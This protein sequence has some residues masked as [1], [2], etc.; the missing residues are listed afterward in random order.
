MKT[1][2][3]LVIR[4]S[5]MGDVAM[6]VPIV[7]QLAQRGDVRVTVLTRK[8]FLPLFAQLNDVET[9]AFSKDL[10][11]L[12][13]FRELR[14]GQKWDTVIDLHNVLR[15]KFLRFL[16]RL[17]GV[18]IA[19]L[20][21]N[22]CQKR[23]LT[24]KHCKKMRQL[25]SVQD[26]YVAACA[27]AGFPVGAKIFSPIFSERAKDFSP[28][29]D[30]ILKITGE[31][32]IG[33]APFA[34]HR[35]KVYPLDKILQVIEHFSEKGV[36]IFLFGG[37]S[38]AETLEN[39]A[40]IHNNVYSLAG[41]TDFTGELQMMAHLDCMLSMDSGNMHLANLVGVPVLSVWGA[42]HPFAG[43]VSAGKNTIVQRNLDCRPCSIFGNKPCWK[44]TYECMDIPPQKIIEEIEKIIT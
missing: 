25:P 20:Q 4:L 17:S 29:P 19:V 21:K 18:K 37:K 32:N 2:N 1:K 28:L 35:T 11:V 5:A 27:R 44:G 31:K 42:T 40:A 26:E 9:F 30:D 7:A 6:C 16:F 14:K 22:R 24:R 33:I 34:K 43:F 12:R 38:D 8:A 3:I 41:K 10:S 39:W 13:L 23:K 36:H 15:T